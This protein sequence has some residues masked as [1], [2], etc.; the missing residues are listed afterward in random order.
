MLEL[1]TCMTKLC[2]FD[3]CGSAHV[4]VEC[5][6]LLTTMQCLALTKLASHQGMPYVGIWKGMWGLT[7]GIQI[8]IQTKMLCSTNLYCNESIYTTL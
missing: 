5:D 7:Y 8:T 1:P 4:A 2:K 3:C 6:V